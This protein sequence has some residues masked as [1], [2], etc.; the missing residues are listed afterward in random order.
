MISQDS[1]TAA[2]S[3][4][5]PFIESLKGLYDPCPYFNLDSRRQIW[6]I[7]AESKFTLAGNL[8]MFGGAAQNFSGGSQMNDILDVA[9]GKTRQFFKHMNE[10][11]SNN[12]SDVYEFF[13]VISVIR[14]K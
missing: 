3:S 6:G 14:S 4:N 9:T 11:E 2:L 12:M 13:A 5:Q 7:N 8:N 10:V 1:Q